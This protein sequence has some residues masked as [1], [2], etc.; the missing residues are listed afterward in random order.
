MSVSNAVHCRLKCSRL[1]QLP[2]RGLSFT[3]ENSDGKIDGRIG[4]YCG[5][6]GSF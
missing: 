3:L 4:D 1:F 5:H 2:F 6:F